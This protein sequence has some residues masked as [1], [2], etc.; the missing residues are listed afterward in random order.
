MLLQWATPSDHMCQPIPSLLEKTSGVNGLAGLKLSQCI[1]TCAML[2]SQILIS[3]WCCI[4]AIPQWGGK[5]W[6]FYKW[7]HSAINEVEYQ[8]DL[9]SIFENE[10]SA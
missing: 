10:P 2:G 7:V 9:H 5:A 8:H 3:T 4:A 1:W 6:V